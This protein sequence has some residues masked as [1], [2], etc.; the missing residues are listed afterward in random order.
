MIIVFFEHTAEH[1]ANFIIGFIILFDK[2]TTSPCHFI[3]LVNR[4][5]PNLKSNKDTS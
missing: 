2:E 3:H 1:V 4:N 5:E